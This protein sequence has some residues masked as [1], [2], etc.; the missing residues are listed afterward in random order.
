[1]PL[2]IWQFDRLGDLIC[3]IISIKQYKKNKK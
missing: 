2:F 3:V 1:M